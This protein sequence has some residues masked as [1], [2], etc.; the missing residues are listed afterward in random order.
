MGPP[1]TVVYIA[2]SSGPGQPGGQPCRKGTNLIIART[3]PAVALRLHARTGGQRKM[4][5]RLFGCAR[6]PVASDGDTNTN[7]LSI[8]AGCWLTASGSSRTWAA[9]FL[10]VDQV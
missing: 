1:I 3:P 6:V 10:G 5:G 8:S 4:S 9:G 7:N 2:L